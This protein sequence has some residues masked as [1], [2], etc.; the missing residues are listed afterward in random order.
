MND[1]GQNNIDDEETSEP[2][3]DWETSEPAETESKPETE[4]ESA[5]EKQLQ[6]MFRRF[7]RVLQLI[8]E[9]DDKLNKNAIVEKLADEKLGTEPTARDTIIPLEKLGMIQL[10][11]TNKRLRGG[12]TFDYYTLTK[13]GLENLITAAS[14]AH[15]GKTFFNPET[16]QHLAHKYQDELPIF[17]LWGNFRAAGIEDL[18]WRRLP[19]FLSIFHGKQLEY[20]V[21]RKSGSYGKQVKPKQVKRKQSK[22]RVYRPTASLDYGRHGTTNFNK[23]PS[24][25]ECNPED[26]EEA[27]LDPNSVWPSDKWRSAIQSNGILR[28]IFVRSLLKQ[29]KKTLHHV[30]SELNQVPKTITGEDSKLCHDLVTEMNALRSKIGKRRIST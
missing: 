30:N 12:K 2:I 14:D 16:F 29:A 13:A 5:Y 23:D 10:V 20:L 22:R 11:K 8:A 17:R 18:A 25:Y 15:L 28:S 9:S 4:T 3:D 24:E 19:L 6:S 27:F 7:L 26:D 1:L 21:Y